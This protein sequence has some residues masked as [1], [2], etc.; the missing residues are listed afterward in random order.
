MI[1]ISK[2]LG[3]VENNKHFPVKDVF[4]SLSKSDICKCS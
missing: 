2:Y 1:I 4:A 3:I